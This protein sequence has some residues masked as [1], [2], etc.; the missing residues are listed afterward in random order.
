VVVGV[1]ERNDAG[2]TS[3]S[4][5]ELAEGMRVALLRARW[6][7]DGEMTEVVAVL[8]EMVEGVCGPIS[9]IDLGRVVFDSEA[10]AD[11]YLFCASV[12]K[13]LSLEYHRMNPALGDLSPEDHLT[14][15]RPALPKFHRRQ[16]EVLRSID[17][18][19][20]RRG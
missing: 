7:P 18:E 20:P 8:R 19:F 11:A 6:E 9:T 3:A 2:M 15:I 13:S 1:A 10:L 17:E 14:M 12:S 16:R 4:A 5:S